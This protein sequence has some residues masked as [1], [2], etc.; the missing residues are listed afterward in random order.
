MVSTPVPLAVQAPV[1]GNFFKKAGKG[2]NFSLQRIAQK[3]V[4]HSILPMPAGFP[5]SFLQLSG[6]VPVIRRNCLL[7][8]ARLLKPQA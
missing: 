1:P 4:F 6:F 5:L 2:R 3:V 7:K 8:F